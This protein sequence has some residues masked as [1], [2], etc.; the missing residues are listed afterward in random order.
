MKTIELIVDVMFVNKFLFMI[1]L[2]KNMKFNIIENVVDRKVATLFNS[3]CSIKVYTQQIWG[4]TLRFVR[5]W[6]HP[7]HY[8]SRWECPTNGD[9]NQDGEGTNPQYMKLTNVPKI[10]KQNDLPHGGK[11]RF[12]AQRAPHK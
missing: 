11:H 12:M 7:Q 3:L 2:G 6:N 10:P 4:V 9:K 5:Q 8:R 1:S